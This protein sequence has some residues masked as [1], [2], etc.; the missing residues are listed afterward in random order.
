MALLLIIRLPPAPR[1]A[2]VPASVAVR[3]AWGQLTLTQTRV[4]SAVVLL[5]WLN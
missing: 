1:T 2:T 5:V 3:G 4:S